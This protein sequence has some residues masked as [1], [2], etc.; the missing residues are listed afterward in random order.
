ML[1]LNDVEGDT[2]IYNEVYKKSYKGNCVKDVDKKYTVLKTIRPEQGKAVCWDGKYYHAASFP[3]PGTR[4]IV[5]VFT[6]I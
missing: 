4:R 3:K 5:V 1:Y 2:K 6:F